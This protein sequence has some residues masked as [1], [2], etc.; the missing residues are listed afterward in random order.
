MQSRRAQ[1]QS[2]PR[3]DWP[4]TQRRNATEPPRQF[5]AIVVT[6]HALGGC[7]PVV[8]PVDCVAEARP[9][10]LAAAAAA[11]REDAASD[12]AFRSA[13]LAELGEGGAAS[14][15]PNG[16]SGSDSG[17]CDHGITA[18]HVADLARTD[19]PLATG[20]ALKNALVEEQASVYSP[21]V[22]LCGCSGQHKGADCSATACP[23]S[24]ASAP[25][26]SQ[27]PAL[28]HRLGAGVARRDRQWARRVREGRVRV[29][30]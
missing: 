12:E 21:R 7:V 30:V 17:T 4:L 14:V 5:F 3:K 26:P 1:G 19:P 10:E 27:R 25:S 13:L 22:G 18:A 20:T 8:R 11:A 6:A 24:C 16:C 15:C 28:T 29:L 23:S 9:H 2:E